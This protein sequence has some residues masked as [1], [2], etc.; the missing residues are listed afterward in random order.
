MRPV[1]AS[2]PP[3]ASCW[4]RSARPRLGSR[5][6]AKRR[7]RE[8]DE[9]LGEPAGRPDPE[10][11]LL[12]L[13]GAPHCA[14]DE[15]APGEP[16]RLGRQVAGRPADEGARGVLV[17]RPER[18]ARE[19]PADQRARADA[20]ARVAESVVNV[21]MVAERADERQVTGR[22]VDGASPRMGKPHVGELRAPAPEV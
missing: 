18:A 13:L 8:R 22:A 5:P 4:P 16:E 17:A 2:P 19:Y 12:A 1:G 21:L 20:V 3:R 6:P 7:Q 9:P 15:R 14:A 11:S 10:A